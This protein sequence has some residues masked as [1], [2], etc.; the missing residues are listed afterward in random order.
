MANMF[1]RASPLLDAP[2]T[3][4][5]WEVEMQTLARDLKA[6]IDTKICVLQVLVRRSEE[7]AERLEAAAARAERLGCRPRPDDEE[8]DAVVALAEQAAAARGTLATPP[9]PPYSDEVYALADAG[10]HAAEIAAQIGLP[11]GDVEFVL[12]LRSQAG[13]FA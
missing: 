11:V 1:N 13:G 3:V 7:A 9:L 8:T 5:R 6:E 12:S 4:V 2:A 10:G